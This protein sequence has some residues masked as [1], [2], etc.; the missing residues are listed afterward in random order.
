MEIRQLD[1]LTD[2]DEQIISRE[3]L[4]DNLEVLLEE[5]YS[6]DQAEIDI[7]SYWLLRLVDNPDLDLYQLQL[8][9]LSE[10][11]A[12]YYDPETDE[13]YLISDNQEMSAND[14]VTMAHEIVHGLQ[15]QHFDLVALDA[16]T[17]NADQSAAL[18]A[19]IEGDATLSMTDYLFSYLS[20]EELLE[21]LMESVDP[22]FSTDV[23]DNAPR[24]ISD[25]L[26]FSYDSGQVFADA[27]NRS[28][29]KIA[30]DQAFADPPLSTEQ[31]LHPEKYL[32]ENRDNP[33]DVTL[34]DLTA[35]LGSDWDLTYSDTLGEWD[36]MIML[37]ENNASNARS[38]YEG[39]GGSRFDLYE[40][41]DEAVVV[42]ETRWDSEED[43]Q[44]F[45]DAYLSTISGDATTDQVYSIDGM[46]VS[47]IAA[48]DSVSIVSG[49]SEQTVAEV[50][51]F[52]S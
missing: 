5:E 50:V 3:Q 29:G 22:S 9:L 6:R 48:G 41:G 21:I 28:N 42:L 14:K 12:G 46:F 7:L 52:L 47:V 35:R 26:I 36:F 45:L 24:Y 27:L 40:S 33:I 37:E 10:Q 31:I 8:D 30:I 44:E 43:A 38:G 20:E 13:L 49:T 1:L 25:G 23:L 34:P 32:S 11:V 51:G 16:M 15:D 18:T 4:R 17:E 2:L 39:W 19:L